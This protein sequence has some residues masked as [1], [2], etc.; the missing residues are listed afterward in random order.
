MSRRIPSALL[1]ALTLS[2][3]FVLMSDMSASVQILLLLACLIPAGMMVFPDARALLLFLFC[4]LL[5][6]EITKGIAHDYISSVV[7]AVSPADLVF[8]MLLLVWV[9]TKLVAEKAA[10][11][12]TRT[13]TIFL[14][15]FAWMGVSGLFSAAPDATTLSL[16]IYAKYFLFFIVMADLLR[17]P[18]YLRVAVVGFGAGLGLQLVTVLAETISPVQLVIAGIKEAQIGRILVFNH[19]GGVVVDRPS[20]LMDH[21]NALAGYLV[22]IL[23]PMAM[24][25]L[26]GS[27]SDRARHWL[28]LIFAGGLAALLLSLSRGG[29]IAFGAALLFMTAV[30]VWTGQLPVRRVTAGLFA[31]A[32]VALIVAVVYP[33]AYLRVVEGDQGSSQARWAL[34]N[35]ATMMIEDHPIAGVGQGAYVK[36]AQSIIPPSYAQFSR[37]E[38]KELLR[39]FV[40]NKYLLVASETGLVGLAL[41]AAFLLRAI[42]APLRRLRSMEPVYRPLAVGLAGAL[43]G[44]AVFFLFDHVAYDMRFGLMMVCAGIAVA[45]SESEEAV[46]VG[47]P[48]DVPAGAR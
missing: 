41:F 34:A 32:C 30:A 13:H 22:M 36:A 27:L 24:L 15:F 48:G 18:A 46:F 29:W 37:A 17:N 8:A 43:F 19:A 6:V 33:P 25:L 21:P 35:Q 7:L 45:L 28:W 44:E 42:V 1:G 26:P 9:S 11:L 23:P 4:F 16:V 12:W 2:A 47:A 38:R 39:L 31:A 10:P 3:L 20:G 5:P 40:H 14:A